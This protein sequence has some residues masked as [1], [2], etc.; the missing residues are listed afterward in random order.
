MHL[1]VASSSN[2][3]I[4]TLDYSF[5]NI[6]RLCNSNCSFELIFRISSTK[7]VD[8]LTVL[9][10][11]PRFCIAMKP[12]GASNDHFFSCAVSRWVP[13]V[14]IALMIE[15]FQPG[16]SADYQSLF[17][18]PLLV[19][20]LVPKYESLG[21][22][23]VQVQAHPGWVCWTSCFASFGWCRSKRGWYGWNGCQQRL[24]SRFSRSR[25]SFR[26]TR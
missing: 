15:N 22:F 19:V 16:L 23:G 26:G 18:V 3:F 25:Q 5:L 9:D 13:L 7:R 17:L 11:V 2:L 6:E 12:R 14:L 1:Y 21:S 24:D 8:G 10:A 4:Q 20:P